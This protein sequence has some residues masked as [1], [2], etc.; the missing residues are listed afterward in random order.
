[1]LFYFSMVIF[2]LNLVQ[3]YFSRMYKNK[4]P[5]SFQEVLSKLMRYCSYQERSPFE[6][7]QKLKEY[8]LPE[9]KADELMDL[10]IADNFI[11]E[12]RF[13]DLFV[14]GKVRVKRWGIYKI[15]EGLYA[16]GVKETIISEATQKIDQEVYLQ[17]LAYLTDRKIELT[18]DVMRDS[19]KLY[20]YL[21]SK[22]Y[23]SDLVIKQLKEK[24][25]MS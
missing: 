5:L 14:R 4:Q 22:G 2:K 19:S 18:P 24:G 16:K 23:E 3:D 15:K 12:E 1:M 21:L 17:N 13:A 20:R 7:K 9:E 11:N 8:R 25:L 6:V 10:L